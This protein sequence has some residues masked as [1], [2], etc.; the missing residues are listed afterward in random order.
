MFSSAADLEIHVREALASDAE[1]IGALCVQLGYETPLV[2]VERM[3]ARRSDDDEV[4]VA[5]VPRIGTIGW[6]AVNTVESLTG[7]RSANIGGLIVEDEYRG[8]GVGALL[9]SRAERWARER[10]CPRLCLRTNVLRERAHGFYER[11]GYAL[12]K[13]QH[14][15]E[16]PLS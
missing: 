7:S 4:F 12:K 9:L 1:R 6:I 10:K 8:V 15:Y 5:I 3:L 13:T 14:F 2:H 16:K 11:Q